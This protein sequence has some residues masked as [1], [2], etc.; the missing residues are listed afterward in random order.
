MT[1]FCFLHSASLLIPSQGEHYCQYGF[2]VPRQHTKQDQLLLHLFQAPVRKAT[3]ALHLSCLLMALSSHKLLFM[4]L[5][6][7]TL[8][9]CS[10]WCGFVLSKTRLRG[11]VL[12]C[13]LFV[14]FSSLTSFF[15]PSPACSYCCALQEQH[16][17]GGCAYGI[18]LPN[19][20]TTLESNAPM[21]TPSIQINHFP[22]AST[23]SSQRSTASQPQLTISAAHLPVLQTCSRVVSLQHF[24][25]TR[26]LLAADVMMSNPS[27][28][29]SCTHC[30]LLRRK[31]PEGQQTLNIP[32][33]HMLITTLKIQP[34]ALQTA[35]SA[36]HNGS[37]QSQPSVLSHAR[38]TTLLHIQETSCHMTCLPQHPLLPSQQWQFTL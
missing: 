2:C 4:S 14:Y 5:A 29:I 3:A 21:A 1:S 28:H 26:T 17:A 15:L 30:L 19:C 38:A 23:Q 36:Q 8:V 16:Q 24:S 10:C 37:A 31:S 7:P 33:R 11:T 12:K 6:T 18:C 32:H 35:H 13:V 34:N 20:T 22:M 9:C 27:L 25:H